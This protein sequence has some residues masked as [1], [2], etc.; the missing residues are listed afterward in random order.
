MSYGNQG[1][2]TSGGQ[3]HSPLLPGAVPARYMLSGGGDNRSA[4]TNIS[5]A[6]A[7]AGQAPHSLC[8]VPNRETDP[9]SGSPQIPAPYL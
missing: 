1:L 7:S 9:L 5:R 6:P 2:R 3:A 8:Q 4:N